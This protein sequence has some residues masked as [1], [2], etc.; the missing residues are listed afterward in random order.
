[1]SWYENT[2]LGEQCGFDTHCDQAEPDGNCDPCETID[3][4]WISAVSDYASTCDGCGELTMHHA[5][6]MDRETQ[7]G[8]CAECVPGL[9]A[10]IGERL[11]EARAEA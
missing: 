11:E 3:G 6:Q 1:M 5:L 10:Q 2:V 8:Y 7:L 9:P 4:R